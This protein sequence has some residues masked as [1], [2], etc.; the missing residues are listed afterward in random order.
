MKKSFFLLAAV[1]LCGCGVFGGKTLES[2]FGT[3][4]GA[5]RLKEVENDGVGTLSYW[6][7][8]KFPAGSVYSYYSAI[9]KQ[10]GWEPSGIGEMGAPLQW[11][12]GLSK[13]PVTLLPV[14]AYWYHA[15]WTDPRKKRLLLL[16]LT[17]YDKAP[18]SGNCLQYPMSQELMVTLQDMP[19][20]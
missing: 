20:Q 14:C 5:E 1:L 19:L 12:N 7:D 4:P 15:A 11:T 10:K 17:Y 13:D 16:Y 18:S 8:L 9:L 3:V 6:V 2:R